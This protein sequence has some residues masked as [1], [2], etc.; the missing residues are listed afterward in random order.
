VAYRQKDFALAAA[1]L[2]SGLI[3]PTILAGRID[4]LPASL[5][6]QAQKRAF[7]AEG[8]GRTTSTA[9]RAR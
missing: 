5:D 9:W 2:E 1:M 8:L 7:M 4:R 6:P 3:D